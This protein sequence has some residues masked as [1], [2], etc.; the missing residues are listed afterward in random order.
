LLLI[1]QFQLYE[2]I[3]RIVNDNNLLYIPT[4]TFVS[5]FVLMWKIRLGISL[6]YGWKK[7]K[8]FTTHKFVI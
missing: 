4:T 3:G 6:L 5:Q 2:E 8:R 7:R 1:Y